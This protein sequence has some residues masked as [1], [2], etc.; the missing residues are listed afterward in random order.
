MFK[1]CQKC[2]ENSQDLNLLPSQCKDLSGKLIDNLQCKQSSVILLYV[3]VISDICTV[4][5]RHYFC[6]RIGEGI[7]V[8]VCLIKDYENNISKKLE[9]Q[10]PNTPTTKQYY[11][12]F[13]PLLCVKKIILKIRFPINTKKTISNTS[14]FSQLLHTMIQF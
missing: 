8:L 4:L 14:L 1:L 9:R 3:S 13:L 2:T 5:Q 10:T 7:K 12:F 6:L 11:T